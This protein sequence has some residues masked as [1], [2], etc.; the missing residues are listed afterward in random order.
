VKTLP[1]IVRASWLRKQPLAVVIDL[2]GHLVDLDKVRQLG[3]PR[4]GRLLK[5]QQELER[6]KFD[7]SKL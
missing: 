5:T 6:R 7:L 2:Y 1:A 4:D 3:E